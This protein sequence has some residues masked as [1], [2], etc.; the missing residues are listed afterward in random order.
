[1]K[2]AKKKIKINKLEKLDISLIK[3]FIIYFLKK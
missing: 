1:M 2:I 3:N